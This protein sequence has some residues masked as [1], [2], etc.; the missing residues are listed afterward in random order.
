MQ[1]KYERIKLIITEFDVEDVI[2]TSSTE[3]EDK[4]HVDHGSENAFSF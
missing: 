4:I 2:T 1:Q 3:P